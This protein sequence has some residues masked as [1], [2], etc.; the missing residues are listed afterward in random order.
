MSRWFSL[1]LGCLCYIS[2]VAWLATKSCRI[3]ENV[4]T[5]LIWWCYRCH[6]RHVYVHINSRAYN[7]NKIY[8][9]PFSQ[10]RMRWRYT[11][12][13]LDSTITELR[14]ETNEKKKRWRVMMMRKAHFLVWR[15][16]GQ[17]FCAVKSNF[18]ATRFV[19]N[20][21][22]TSIY[23]HLRVFIDATFSFT[24]NQWMS[25]RIYSTHTHTHN[26]Q[27][28]YYIESTDTHSYTL[29]LNVCSNNQRQMNSMSECVT[30]V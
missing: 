27:C 21:K 15:S 3:E 19:F 1:L 26:V 30:S 23:T 29:D 20:G 16:N 2:A 4:C 18:D 22:S 24:F 11:V 12:H 25:I 6:R 17:T 8:L 14:K 13:T 10:I 28:T 7:R 9:F 5:C